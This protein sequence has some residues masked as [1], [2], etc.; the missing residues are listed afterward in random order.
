MIRSLVTVFAGGCLLVLT[1]ATGSIGTIRSSGDFRVDGSTVRGNGT[2]FDG[3]LI[4]TTS[5]RSVV[6][7]HAVQITL[8]PE[9]RAKI[10]Q[11]HTVLEKG[12]GL[13]RDA[14]KHVLDAAS[15]E[16][17]PA[18]KD[19][20]IQVD[21][22]GPGRISVAARSG[23]AQVRNS[24]GVLV[25]TLLAGTALEFDSQAGA[26]TAVKI[27]GVVELRNGAYFMTD[28]TTHVVSQLLGANL[29]QFVGKNTHITGSLIPGA[30]PLAGA[31]QVV[32]VA[33]SRRV[34]AG[35]AG[36]A[37]S[38]GTAGAPGTTGASGTASASGAATGAAAVGS[39]VAVLAIIGGVAVGGTVV[40]LA[41]A[42]SFSGTPSTS[43]K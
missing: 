12:A 30:V 22:Q 10:Y 14:D 5:A 38:V 21:V 39:H 26:S 2:L 13:L 9:S 36:T 7:L 3:N 8:A 33:D 35:A 15:L 6:Q 43:A 25:A 18:G 40:G 28:V 31:T 34:A 32:Q 37:G 42:G 16:I 11:D 23:G 24:S 4:E 1:A 41:A 19:A 17:A 27:S 29:A 20:V